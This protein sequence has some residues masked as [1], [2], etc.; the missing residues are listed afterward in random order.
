MVLLWVAFVRADIYPAS[1]DTWK[2]V[3]ALVEVGRWG[4]CWI[5]S[6]DRHTAC[7]KGYRL[8]WATIVLQRT[9]IKGHGSSISKIAGSVAC[10][11]HATGVPD[12]VVAQ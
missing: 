7:L 5:A 2:T 11:R 9:K 6:V 10:Y 1:D 8:S 12:K 4:K 3:T